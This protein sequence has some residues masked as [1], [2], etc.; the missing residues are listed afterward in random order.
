[1]STGLNEVTVVFFVF[2]WICCPFLHEGQQLRWP[3]HATWA[4][5]SEHRSVWFLPEVGDR[6]HG[7]LGEALRPLTWEFRPCSGVGLLPAPVRVYLWMQLPGL[8][9]PRKAVPNACPYC[10]FVPTI[11]GSHGIFLLVYFLAKMSALFVLF[12]IL[13]VDHGFG[14][15]VF[16][17]Y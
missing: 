8:S 15:I 16:L 4:P 14:Q 10:W 6:A 7:L 11:F 13:W 2:I 17:Y 9:Q 3:S 5:G 12:S 1:M